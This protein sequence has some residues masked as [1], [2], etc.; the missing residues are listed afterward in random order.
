MYAQISFSD[1]L[2]ISAEFSGD[3]RNWCELFFGK[4]RHQTKCKLEKYLY[5]S[6]SANQNSFSW[7]S[8]L[9][10]LGSLV[11]VCK[12]GLSTLHTHRGHFCGI[13]QISTL[14]IHIIWIQPC[15]V[16]QNWK[17]LFSLYFLISFAGRFACF[18]ADRC[19]CCPWAAAPVGGGSSAGAD[20]PARP[21]TPRSSAR[22][23]TSASPGF[24]PPPSAGNFYTAVTLTV[25]CAASINNLHIQ[26]DGLDQPRLYSSHRPPPGENRITLLGEGGHIQRKKNDWICKFTRKKLWCSPRLKW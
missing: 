20:P 12:P 3:I 10:R 4:Q 23:E 21:G 2:N 7:G 13:Q 15:K 11:S 5:N 26:S 9:K 1:K 17:H 22:H 16:T 14:L 25:A 24:P 19:W 6:L 8:S 18:P